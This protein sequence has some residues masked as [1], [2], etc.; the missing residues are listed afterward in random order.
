MSSF[1]IGIMVMLCEIVKCLFCVIMVVLVIVL[2]LVLGIGRF[3]SVCVF[4]V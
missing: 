4:W 2:V 1:L 3:K